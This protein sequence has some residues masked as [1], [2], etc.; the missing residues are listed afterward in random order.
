M[1]KIHLKDLDKYSN[2]ELDRDIKSNYVPIKSKKDKN[3]VKTQ[4]DL[5]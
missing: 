1:A 4:K 3:K 2:E 5:H